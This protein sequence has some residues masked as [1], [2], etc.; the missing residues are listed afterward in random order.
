[1]STFEFIIAVPT[2][3]K[4]HYANSVNAQRPGT[5]LDMDVLIADAREVWQQQLKCP[6]SGWDVVDYL[7]N[8]DGVLGQRLNTDKE[9]ICELVVV[10]AA[11]QAASALLYGM[12]PLFVRGHPYS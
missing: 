8:H 7:S 11:S 2:S 6:L 10:E 3:G 9:R 12:R 4:T 1:M 5:I